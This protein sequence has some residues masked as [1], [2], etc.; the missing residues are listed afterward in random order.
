MTSR[1]VR[2]RPESNCAPPPSKTNLHAHQR[3]STNEVQSLNSH[4]PARPTAT[5][6]TN[7]GTSTRWTTALVHTRCPLGK[8]P[9]VWGPAGTTRCR[10][11]FCL[12]Y[13]EG[14]QSARVL[15]CQ[16]D[17]A[18]D[19]A[20]DQ[21]RGRWTEHRHVAEPPSKSTS[22]RPTCEVEARIAAGRPPRIL[23]VPTR[24]SANSPDATRVR[25]QPRTRHVKHQPETACWARSSTRLGRR[26]GG[27]RP[28]DILVTRLGCLHEKLLA[29]ARDRQV[30]RSNLRYGWRTHVAS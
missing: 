12:A 21:G 19:R 24:N 27:A 3:H 13:S 25:R 23:V 29:I 15:F 9:N 28:H 11:S 8:A 10:A 1:H 14:A 22:E 20:K 4:A 2:P 26:A 7:L 30:L 6:A 5:T 18:L 17:N 16:A